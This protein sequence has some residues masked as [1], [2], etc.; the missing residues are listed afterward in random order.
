MSGADR[1]VVIVGAG[2]TGLTAGVIL[3]QAGVDV[4]VLE[5]RDRVGGRAYGGPDGVDLG[6][7]WFWANEPSV[8]A[9]ADA[10]RIKTF[11]Q[12]S[13]GDALFDADRADVPPTRLAGNP[14]DQ[15]SGRFAGGAQQLAQGLAR[16]LGEGR[17]RRSTPV[18]RVDVS[19]EHVRVTTD[20][21]ETLSAD[22]V[23]LAMP[24]ALAAATITIE[25]ALD[26]DLQTVSAA[27]AT[28]MGGMVKAVARLDRPFWRDAGLAGSAISYLGPFREFHD[29][30]GP[31]GTPAAIFGFAPAAAFAGASQDDIAAAFTA[32]VQRMWGRGGNILGV[33]LVDWSR[34]QYTSVP[35][36][37]SGSTDVYGHPVFQQPVAGGRLMIA[38]TETAHAYAGHLEGAMQAG[39]HA[40]NT[41][42]ASLHAATPDHAAHMDDQHQHEHEEAQERA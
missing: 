14:I 41:L 33:D 18:R 6:A 25:P 17:I 5:A 1:R 13:A 36:P 34:E 16:T 35:G 19:G 8:A 15:P 30:S 4:I 26:E 31:D 24:P 32:Q 38:S 23:L 3:R 9:I 2:M 42:L 29:H 27:T 22:A 28:W 39:A 20:A 12:W 7:T 11:P 37:A 10:H 40:A 21:G